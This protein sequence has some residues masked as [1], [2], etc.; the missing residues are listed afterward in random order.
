MESFKNSQLPCQSLR[1]YYLNDCGGNNATLLSGE[2]FHNAPTVPI[3]RAKKIVRISD[4]GKFDHGNHNMTMVHTGAVGVCRDVTDELG[5]LH[6]RFAEPKVRVRKAIADCI[7]FGYLPPN[8]TID[9][10][11]EFK[12][13]VD[14]LR[15]PAANRAGIH[16]IHMVIKAFDH[17]IESV[18]ETPPR[19]NLIRVGSFQEIIARVQ[20]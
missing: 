1:R 18:R 15:N 10:L 20:L 8:V 3:N 17:G 14:A 4:L 5:L 2:Y 13:Q 16:K 6:Y 9:N 12:Y 7:G 19:D 11:H